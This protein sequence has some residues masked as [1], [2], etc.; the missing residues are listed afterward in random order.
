MRNAGN[1]F[2]KQRITLI[3]VDLCEEGGGWDLL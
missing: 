2:W 3:I 1:P